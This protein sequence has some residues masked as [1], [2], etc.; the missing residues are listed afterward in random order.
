MR[1]FV[2]KTGR[3]LAVAV[4]FLAACGSERPAERPADQ[5]DDAG[6]VSDGSGL[7]GAGEPVAWARAYRGDLQIDGV[8]SDQQG[9]VYAAGYFVGKADFGESNVLTSISG[10]SGQPTKDIFL[11]KH[12]ASGQVL[13]VR[14]F[15]GAGLEG[16]IYDVVTNGSGTTFASGA[17]SGVVDFDG[18]TLTSTVE[19]GSGS[20]SSGAYG[21]MV[22]A[23]IATDGSTRWAIQAIGDVVSGGNEVAIGPDG[24]LGQVGMF[25]GTQAA[26]GSM[27]IDAHPLPFDGGWFDTYVARFKPDGSILWL[28]HIGGA[29]SQRGKGI[30]FDA[31]GNVLVVGDAWSGETRFGPGQAFTAAGD[32]SKQDFWAAKYDAQ[33]AL[34]WFRSFASSGRDEVKGVGGDAA[35]NVIVA[36]GFS[37]PS[38]GVLDRNVTGAAPPGGATG[39]V[40]KLT[41]DGGKVLFTN[42]IE[43]VLKCCEILVDERGHTY[44][45]LGA[46]GPSVH[47][48]SGAT[49][50]VG[51]L[52]QGGLLV[53]FD[54]DGIPVATATFEADKGSFGELSL[55]PRGQVVVTASY[56]GSFVHG[57]IHLD[58]SATSSEAL[59]VT[60]PR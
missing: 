32:E 25:G 33:G 41:P 39:L 13:W 58:G 34:L 38:I 19:A 36:A 46:G 14:Q 30:A 48:G 31:E 37:G 42:T 56:E 8:G 24:T 51:G 40:F 6:I 2:F 59:L 18:K 17:F 12:A 57:D 9:A 43:F 35:G 50:E 4:P 16:N 55:L 21:N 7:D 60:T 44:A 5:P 15:G 29:G 22:L 11:S 28:A 52:V 3:F 26:G 10:G 47:F 49:A 27:T 20:G 54:P 23:S 53:D 1:R 45:G